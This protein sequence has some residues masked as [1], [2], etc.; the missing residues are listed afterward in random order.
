MD[1]RQVVAVVAGA[2]LGIGAGFGVAG[3]G[4]EERGGVEVEGAATDPS[5][6]AT[7]GTEAE[8]STAP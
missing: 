5:G 6:A 1:R 7:T 2:A 4:D 8:T 3:C